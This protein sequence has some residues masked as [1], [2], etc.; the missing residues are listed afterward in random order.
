MTTLGYRPGAVA[1]VLC[2]GK[3][4]AHLRPERSLS[5]PDIDNLTCPQHG[6]RIFTSPK[7]SLGPK[8]DD[9]PDVARP[10]EWE[11]S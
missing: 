7:F 1:V 9:N 2:C 5:A 10:G 6:I 8:D 11:T 4:G 3:C